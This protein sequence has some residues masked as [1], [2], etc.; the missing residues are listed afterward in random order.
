MDCLRKGVDLGTL[1][2]NYVLDA[3]RIVDDW[4]GQGLS[5]EKYYEY[6][7]KML[8][9]RTGLPEKCLVNLQN[10]LHWALFCENGSPLELAYNTNRDNGVGYRVQWREEGRMADVSSVVKRVLGK[11]ESD[12][13]VRLESLETS[14]AV[15]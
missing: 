3:F 15:S 9:E 13:R 4:G 5:M 8:S 12:L 6:L 11:Y 7:T 2:E 10:P 14:R 1:V